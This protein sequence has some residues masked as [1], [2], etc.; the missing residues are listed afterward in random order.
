MVTYYEQCIFYIY[1]T[2]GREK[3]H[4]QQLI[5]INGTKIHFYNLNFY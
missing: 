5:E 4:F 3:N 2:A 1:D